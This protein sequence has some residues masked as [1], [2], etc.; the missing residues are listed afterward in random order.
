MH[1][2]GELSCPGEAIRIRRR[3]AVLQQRL[4]REGLQ[5]QA[6]VGGTAGAGARFL[7][8]G[9]EQAELCLRRNVVAVPETAQGCQSVRCGGHRRERRVLCRP[10]KPVVL[11][12]EGEDA[13]GQDIGGSHALPEPVGDSAEILADDGAAVALAFQ[14]RNGQKIVERIADIS[15]R[16]RLGAIGNQKQAL[17]AHHM[18]DS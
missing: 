12:L 10:A 6:F 18:I 14:R 15:A 16:R 8:G 9:F 4:I 1:R 7:I 5:Q 13:A 2:Q 11:A 17:P 3:N